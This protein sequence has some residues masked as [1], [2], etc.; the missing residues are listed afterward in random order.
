MIHA[1]SC[2]FLFDE[3][4]SGWSMM[5]NFVSS[6]RHHHGDSQQFS[7]PTRRRTQHR[8]AAAALFAFL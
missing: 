1:F 2:F 5:I 8:H 4:R 7:L 6:S 3:H